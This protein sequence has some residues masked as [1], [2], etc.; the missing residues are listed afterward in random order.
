[1]TQRSE[2]VV[3]IV[4]TRKGYLLL[5]NGKE[6]DGKTERHLA[7]RTFS[8]VSG[9]ENLG[10]KVEP[11]QTRIDAL[12]AESWQE[13]WISLYDHQV[14]DAGFGVIV[15]QGG[16]GT[17]DVTVYFLELYWWQ[18][19]ILKIFK[20]AKEIDPLNLDSTEIRMRDLVI[21]QLAEDKI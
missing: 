1:M 4:R 6:N 9:L 3:G 11:G 18:I 5:P 8:P 17:F 13:G 15:E 14:N 12:K 19:A 7:H 10:G 16:R 20:R 21:L 2:G